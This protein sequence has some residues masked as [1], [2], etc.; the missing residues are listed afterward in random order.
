MS[1]WTF[2][3]I[4]DMA[5]VVNSVSSGT[6]SH[7]LCLS[8]VPDACQLQFMLLSTLI[9]LL[10]CWLVSVTPGCQCLY[11]VH[12]V[13]CMCFAIGWQPT[14]DV[15]SFVL[16]GPVWWIHSKTLLSHCLTVRITSRHLSFHNNCTI[17]IIVKNNKY[18]NKTY[19]MHKVKCY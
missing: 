13:S 16:C 15:R 7:R 6:M 17:T 2:S 4:V 1:S 8:T 9:H 11:S 19:N 5:F 10:L 14:V 12:L 3:L 18:S